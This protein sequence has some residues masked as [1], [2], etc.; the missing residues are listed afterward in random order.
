MLKVILYF[1]GTLFGV[2]IVT[3]LIG[4][5]FG[6]LVDVL[7]LKN[8]C[9]NTDSFL[10]KSFSCLSAGCIAFLFLLVFTAFSGITIA[11]ILLFGKNTI[12]LIIDKYPNK[13][14]MISISGYS[15]LAIMTILFT[16]FVVPYLGT[17]ISNPQ[18]CNIYSQISLMNE[19]CYVSGLMFMLLIWFGYII[20][21]II[22]FSIYGCCRKKPQ[23]INKNLLEYV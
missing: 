15:Y 13:K 14:M 3:L 21:A 6:N 9:N 2:L 11:P 7:Y 1:I 22:G 18:K 16:I 4:I 20:L 17:I 8:Y 23:T 12:E 19:E 5:I 10:N